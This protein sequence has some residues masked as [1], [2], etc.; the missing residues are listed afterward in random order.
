[1]TS[2][3][4][5]KCKSNI[6][7]MKGGE[8]VNYK[9]CIPSQSYHCYSLSLLQEKIAFTITTC[10]ATPSKRLSISLAYRDNQHVSPNSRTPTSY[11]QPIGKVGIPISGKVHQTI[12]C[13][14]KKHARS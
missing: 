11:N 13:A 12:K 9:A 3:H 1:M 10:C 7:R 4:L 2:Y 8:D 5:V 6:H 14:N